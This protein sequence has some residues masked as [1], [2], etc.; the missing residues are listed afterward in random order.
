MLV[1]I[2]AASALTLLLLFL[3][4]R[5]RQEHGMQGQNLTKV[6]DTKE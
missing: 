6:P 2:L 3:L 1:P 5:K 4:L